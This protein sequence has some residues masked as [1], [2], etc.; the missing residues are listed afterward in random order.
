MELN[1]IALFGAALIP[2][3]TGAIW[4]NPKVFGTAW[5][6][7][8]GVTEESMKGANMAMIFGFTY[9]LSL[10]FSLILSTMVIHQGHL[11]SILINEPGFQD[12]QSEVG[13]MF[14]AFMENYGQNFR[15]F[16]HGIFHGVLAGFLFAL[17]V[18]GINA[19]FERK[20][21]KLIALNAGYWFLTAG[22]MG[23]VISAYL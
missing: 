23:G 6:R 22:L 4:Y 19:L 13:Q 20:S 8:S 2:L 3:V 15:T 17:P 21:F 12:P 7:E 10:L 9:L 5:M 14:A 16:K 11:S 1:W 18:L